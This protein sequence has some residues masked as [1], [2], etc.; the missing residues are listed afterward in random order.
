[1]VN[2]ACRA[3]P[4]KDAR[5]TRKRKPALEVCSAPSEP[6][7]FSEVMVPEKIT[8]QTAATQCETPPVTAPTISTSNSPV[9]RRQTAIVVYREMASTGAASIRAETVG[10]HAARPWLSAAPQAP[11]AIAASKSAAPPESS[12]GDSAVSFASGLAVRGE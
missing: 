4:M 2:P 7:D 5:I 1:M 3:Q 6:Y 12:S 10:T 8:R 9:M 11:G